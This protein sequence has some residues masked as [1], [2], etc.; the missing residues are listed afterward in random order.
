MAVYDTAWNCS[1]IYR[2]GVTKLKSAVCHSKANTW[3]MSVGRK[4]KIAFSRDLERLA[5]WGEDRLVSKENF[6]LLIRGPEVLKGSFRSVQVEGEGR[7]HHSQLWQSSWCWLLCSLI[8]VILIV[9]STI[10]PQLEK[11]MAPT[12][13]LLP[14]KSHGWRSLVGCSPWSCEESDTAEPLHFGFSLSCIGEGNGNPLQ[15]SCLENPRNRGAWWAAVYGVAQSQT[16][17]KQLSSSSRSSNPQ[18]C[19]YCSWGSLNKNTEV[20]CYSLLQWTTFCQT[21]PPWPVRLGWPHTAWISFVELH[22]AVVHVIRLGSCLW[23]WF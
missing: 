21:S 1:R 11:A 2:H 17:L 18:L 10:N 23:L 5:T 20:V 9:L 14:G 15:C 3:E 12:P 22:K 6:Q 13:V 7:V 4:W 16:W 8:S 19:S